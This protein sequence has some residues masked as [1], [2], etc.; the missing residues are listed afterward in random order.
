MIHDVVS[1]S[2]G[3]VDQGRRRT[4]VISFDRRISRE[5]VMCFANRSVADLVDGEGK[6]EQGTPDPEKPQPPTV[7]KTLSWGTERE[8]ASAIANKGLEDGNL[9]PDSDH[10]VLCRQYQ[11]ALEKIFRM[12]KILHGLLA[13]SDERNSPIRGYTIDDLNRELSDHWPDPI[14]IGDYLQEAEKTAKPEP[15][16][17]PL[18][19]VPKGSTVLLIMPRNMG[20]TPDSPRGYSE[21]YSQADVVA[22][23]YDGCWN[24]VKDVTR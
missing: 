1:M 2:A 15:R 20:K 4:I 9:D 24:I 19:V 18:R 3:L 8:T 21:I 12:S 14:N 22:E 5:A 6:L 11:R 10:V 23:W 16:A 13:E 7:S 17:L